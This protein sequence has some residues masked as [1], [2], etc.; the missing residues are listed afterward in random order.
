MYGLLDLC[1]E[2]EPGEKSERRRITLEPNT[3]KTV[4][5]PIV[6]LKTGE[7]NL[8]IVALSPHGSDVVIKTLNVVAQGM[9]F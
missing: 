8:K 4:A 7:F 6:A 2:A 5:F 3:A 1:S 9:L